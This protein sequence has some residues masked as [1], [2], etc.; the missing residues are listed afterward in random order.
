[1]DDRKSYTGYAFIYAG[2]AV[3]W[4]SRKQRTVALSTTEAEYMAIGDAAKE[5]IHLKLFLKEVLGV[6]YTVTILN[7][8]QGAGGLSR[9]PV[10]HSRTKHVDIRHHFIRDLIKAEEVNIKYVSTEEMQ[11]DVLTKALTRAKHNG[12]ILGL[13]MN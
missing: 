2:A 4:E 12:C 8:N 11:A 10:F 7:D 5:A 13:G 1:V 3:S 6:S 9:N